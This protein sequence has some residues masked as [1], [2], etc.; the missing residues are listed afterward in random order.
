MDRKKAYVI[1]VVLVGFGA[2][3]M[4]LSLFNLAPERNEAIFFAGLLSFLSG[5]FMKYMAR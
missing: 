5:F 3:F 2:I 4:L 1:S